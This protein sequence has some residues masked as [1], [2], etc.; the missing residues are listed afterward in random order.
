MREVVDVAHRQPQLLVAAQVEKAAGAVV[1]RSALG[2]EALLLVGVPGQEIRTTGPAGQQDARFLE[3]LPHDGDPVGQAARLEAQQGARPRIGAAQA[4]GLGLG[5]AV[6]RVDGAAGEHVRTADEVR[7][8][9]APDHQHLKRG[10]PGLRR[11]VPHQHDRG[12]RPDLDL[13]R[14]GRVRGG[15]WGR[16]SRW[17]HAGEGTGR[18]GR[19]PRKRGTP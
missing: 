10:S 9:V 11:G 19:R 13:A 3:G 12:G 8:Q 17:R 18:S 16:G 4:Q 15:S 5:T 14:A 6:Q 7:A 2:C 1:D